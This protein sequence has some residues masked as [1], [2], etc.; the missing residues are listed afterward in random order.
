M[1]YRDD[2]KFTWNERILTSI[3]KDKS[4]INYTYNYDGIRIAKDI[5]GIET[6]YQLDGAKI[7]SE[8]TNGNIKWYIYDQNDSI[9][10]FEYNDNVYYFEKNAQNDI[11][12]IFDEDGNYISEYLYDSWGNISSILGNEEVAT[13][14]P[15]RY[16]SYYYDI[17][18]GLYYLQSRYYDSY[19]GR[20]INAD[21]VNQIENG[22]Y[23]L[24]IYCSDNT[25]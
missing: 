24:Y 6:T 14:N 16:R 11:V 4:L 23:N 3:Q 9:I 25:V 13:A 19:T 8:T 5:N 10:G 2:M 12:R 20:F 18:S 1:S 17:E 7:V 22:E 15:F 21:N